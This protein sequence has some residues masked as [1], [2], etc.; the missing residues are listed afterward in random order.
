MN[1]F[2]KTTLFIYD[3]SL[4]AM[5][6]IS[7]LLRVAIWA[8]YGIYMLLYLVAHC[9]VHIGKSV[10]KNSCAELPLFTTNVRKFE[11]NYTPIIPTFSVA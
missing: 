7:T 8:Y 10:L 4:L 9:V 11:T 5:Y 2:N 6:F 3:S 1:K